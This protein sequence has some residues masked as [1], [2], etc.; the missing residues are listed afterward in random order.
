MW[1]A[2]MDLPK[3]KYDIAATIVEQKERMANVYELTV[4]CEMIPGLCS[5]GQFAQIGLPAK[6]SFAVHWALQS[7]MKMQRH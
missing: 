4:R 1:A 6:S 7:M 3:E 5:P 2:V